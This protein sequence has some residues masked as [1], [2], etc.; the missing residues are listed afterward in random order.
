MVSIIQLFF[1]RKI[2]LKHNIFL[3]IQTEIRKIDR[4][5]STITCY[6]LYKIL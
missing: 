6:L 2:N 3:E 4:T 1:Y 5:Y